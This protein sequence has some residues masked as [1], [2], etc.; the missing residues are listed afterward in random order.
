M[1]RPKAD[2]ALGLKD[3]LMFF[4][5]S[6]WVLL[7]CA[8]VFKSKSDDEDA[9]PALLATLLLTKRVKGPPV[10]LSFIE[11]ERAVS[12]GQRFS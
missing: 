7:P 4:F 9:S 3:E 10:M 8:C 2:L 11:M 5:N 1:G 12:F 6:V